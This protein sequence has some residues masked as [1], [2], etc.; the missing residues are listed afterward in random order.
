MDRK[1]NMAPFRKGSP[2]KVYVRETEHI[3]PL[4][5]SLSRLLPVSFPE[6]IFPR[7]SPELLQYYF[8]RPVRS[9][10]S[11]QYSPHFRVIV[12]H[13]FSVVL[14]VE[15]LGKFFSDVVDG[16]KPGEELPHNLPAANEVH[17]RDVGRVQDVF[18]G[19]VG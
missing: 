7:S 14:D 5:S 19:P 16:E 8:R 2:V 4:V 11:A 9:T 18:E 1:I 13:I 6:L 3:R 10:G 12:E 17:Q 15:K